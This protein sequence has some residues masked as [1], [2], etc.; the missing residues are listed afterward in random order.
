MSALENDKTELVSQVDDLTN[1]VAKLELERDA[2]E[3]YSRRNCVRISGIR[4]KPNEDTDKIILDMAAAMGSDISPADLDR[5][6]RVGKQR[7]DKSKDIIV[8]FATYRARDRF[9]RQRTSLKTIVEYDNVFINEDL[10][11][12]RNE[13][14]FKARKLIKD[15]NSR[16][17]QT[18]SW[19]GRIFVKDSD[20]E[21]HLITAESDLDQFNDTE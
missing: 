3:Q 15:T 4:I 18:W 2:A 16:V 8:K 20:D 9:I 10:T 14:L 5:S 11:K 1:R 19:D 21:C 6:H 12:Q 13:L 17:S 7:K